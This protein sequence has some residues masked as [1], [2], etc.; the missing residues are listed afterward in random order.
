MKRSFGRYRNFGNKLVNGF[1]ESG[2]LAI[3]EVLDRAQ[4]ARQVGGAVAEIG[5][6]HGRLFIGLSLLQRPGE[7]SVAIDLFGDQ[8]MNIDNSGRGDYDRFENNVKLWSSM[9]DVVIQQGDSTK[10][11][12]EVLRDK[13]GGP[14]RFFS[15]D[16]GHTAEIVYSD[17][18]LAE[19][20]LVDGGVVIADD[21]FNQQWPGVAVG[22]LKYLAD[23]AK[24]VPFAIGFNK[25]FF[26][27]PDYSDYYRN[28]LATAFTGSMRIQ[29]EDTVFDGHDVTY[30][31]PMTAVDIARKSETAR[32]IYR[33]AYKGVVQGLQ[34][35][36]G[37]GTPGR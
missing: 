17:M 25:V 18:Q 21:I 16:G 28:E 13:A 33:G 8:A 34:L 30:L 31:A 19:A 15:V 37:K 5:V 2:V 11:A 29:F 22:T 1:M 23:G 20:T 6:H 7:K 3:A 14:I 26:A 10:L 24:L 12:P 36:T 35:V 27:Q 4:R 9:D 32:S